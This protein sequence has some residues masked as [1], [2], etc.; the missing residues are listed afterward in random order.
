[1]ALIHVNA[2]QNI[3]VVTKNTKSSLLH[4]DSLLSLLALPVTI[5]K[6]LA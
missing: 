5:I 6:T 4:A 1:V 3:L 2:V